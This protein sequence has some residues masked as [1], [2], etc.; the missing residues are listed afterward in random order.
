MNRGV[1]THGL[2]ESVVSALAETRARTLEL[3]ADLSPATLESVHSRLLS[4]LVWDLGHIAAF[5]D[6]WI[7]RTL[8]TTML[9]PELVS[10]YD[11]DETPRAERGSLPMLRTTE[12]FDHLEAVRERTMTLLGERDGDFEADRLELIVRHEQQHNETMLQ[13]FQL[14]HLDAPFEQP[15][16]DGDA[17]I[18]S[19]GGG[20]ESVPVA[21]GTVSVGAAPDAGFA[22]D[23][24]RPQHTVEVSPFRIGLTPV[25]NGAWLEFVERG[26]YSDRALW[27]EEGWRWR[28]G[29]A[30]ERP[31]FWTADL[32]QWRLG[33]CLPIEPDEPVVHVS[34]FEAEAFARAHDARLPTEFEWELSATWDR[35]AGVARVHPWGD[36]QAGPEFANVDQRAG[37]PVRMGSHPDGVSPWGVLGMIGDVWEWTSSHFAGYPGFVAYPYR[38]Y[39]EQFFGSRYRVLRG[40]A[41]AT[42][43]RMATAAFRNWDLPQRRQI[44]SGVRLAWEAA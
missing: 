12:A 43:P 7:S 44:F 32:R 11:A 38:E 17:V 24:E 15:A 29:E 21:G 9:R 3:V 1:P 25:S 14:A 26:G 33:E 35:E 27:S 2:V 18:P 4:P 37:G 8:G 16:G 40:A 23:N 13:S 34:H 6:L 42:R 19:P 36:E 39:S 31:L 5:E 41:W 30:V 28:T 22:Y 20:L 10:V